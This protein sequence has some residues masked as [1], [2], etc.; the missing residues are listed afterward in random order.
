MKQQ[1]NNAWWRGGV[2]YQI[3]PRSYQDHNG[4]GVGDLAGI[5][6]RLPYIADLG[7]DAIWIS[8][9]FKS[10]MKDFGYDVSDYRAIDPLFG[11]LDEFDQLVAQTHKLGMKL[12]IDQVISHSSDQHE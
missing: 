7:V 1:E 9:F 11:T 6:K 5:I 2:V 4:D 10:P 3:Y 8:P 12:I